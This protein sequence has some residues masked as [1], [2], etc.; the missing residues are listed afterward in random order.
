M[1]IKVRSLGLLSGVELEP[2]M[3]SHDMFLMP[4]FAAQ[5]IGPDIQPHRLRLDDVHLRPSVTTLPSEEPGNTFT[6]QEGF[7]TDLETGVIEEQVCFGMVSSALCRT[8]RR[9]R[10]TKIGADSD[11]AGTRKS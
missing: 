2:D 3:F 1:L 11:I 6:T 9:M 10:G 5:H 8:S 4:E 7:M